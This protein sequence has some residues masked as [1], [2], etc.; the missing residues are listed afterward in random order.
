MKCLLQIPG[1]LSLGEAGVLI[2]QLNS[3]TLLLR[4]VL[5]TESEFFMSSNERV[6]TDSRQ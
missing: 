6:H 4:K 2:V 5:V 1:S 3:T